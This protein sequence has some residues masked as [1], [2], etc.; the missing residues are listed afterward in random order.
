MPKEHYYGLTVDGPN[1]SKGAE[2]IY[3][4]EFEDLDDALEMAD[5]QRESRLGCDYIWLF[6][7]AE[8]EALGESIK[9]HLT[10][11]PEPLVFES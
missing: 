3:L 6:T 10:N 1:A 4:G 9:N 8:L 7:R 2:C 5:F 11:P